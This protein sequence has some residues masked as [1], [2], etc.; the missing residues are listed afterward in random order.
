MG[1]LH[2]GHLSLIRRAAA[3]TST[4]AVT[5]YVNPLQFGPGEDA[6]RYP[7]DLDRDVRAASEAGAHLV[8]AP[9]A[10]EMWPEPPAT[11]VSVAGLT[12]RWEAVLRPGHFDGVATIVAKLLALAGRCHAF[13]GEKDYQQLSVVRRLAADLSLPAAVVGCPTVREADGLALS[14]RNAYLTPEE[15]AAAPRLYWALLAGRRAVEDDA[16]ARPE[17]VGEAMAAVL[18]A[19]PR[20]ALDYAAVVRPDDLSVPDAVAG[21]VRLLAAGRLGTT[22]LID[23]LPATS[24][25]PVA[26][27]RP[28]EL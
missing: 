2:G 20:W 22:R 3:A 17:D 5:V 1:A 18:A 21:E 19:E 15:R 7:R 12:E 26:A 16:C 9:D 11:T 23:N 8:F 24:P 28:E 25:H 10:D 6:A 13:F 27:P 4:V 14:S